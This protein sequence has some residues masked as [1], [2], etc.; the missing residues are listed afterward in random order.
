MFEYVNYNFSR[1]P[2]CTRVLYASVEAILAHY[3]TS[4]PGH[5]QMDR[6]DF[7]LLCTRCTSVDYMEGALHTNQTGELCGV[8]GQKAFI[9]LEAF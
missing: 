4:F 7:E 2:D 5:F 8:S 3:Y 1:L 9:C 6:F